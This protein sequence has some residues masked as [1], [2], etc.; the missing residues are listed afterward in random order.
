MKR[1][2]MGDGSGESF[3]MIVRNEMPLPPIFATGICFT[4]LRFLIVTPSLQPVTGLGLRLSSDYPV[5]ALK[6][7][8]QPGGPILKIGII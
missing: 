3:L 4:R 6:F 8:L 2:K 1:P 5:V 7:S